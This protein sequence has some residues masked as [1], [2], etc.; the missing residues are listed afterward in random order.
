[1]ASFGR[2]SKARMIGLH[3]DL[4]RLFEEVVKDFDCTV[5]QYGGLRTPDI[6]QML[7][8]K[9]MS[10][11]LNSNHLTGN[12]IDVMPYPVNWNDRETLMRFAA[13][14]YQKAMDM[15]I[16]VRWGGTFTGFFDGPHW[17]I[18]T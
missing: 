15:G 13:H 9:G 12:A 17:E 1:M 3:P 14:V 18:I 7:F 10:K 6:Q 8:D 5:M 2:T 11:T 16:R 4:V